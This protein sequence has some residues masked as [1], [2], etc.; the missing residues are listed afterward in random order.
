MIS[1]MKKRYTANKEEILEM[2]N[3]NKTQKMILK[4]QAGDIKS[5]L[6][7]MVDDG[8][9]PDV[10]SIAELETTNPD[11]R[12]AIKKKSKKYPG[13]FVYLFH[14]FKWGRFG[15][16][17]KF[18]YEKGTW[19][20]LKP[21]PKPPT[22]DDKFKSA[23]VESYKT[24]FG[25]KTKE[26]ALSSGW[27]LTNLEK[28][29]INGVELYKPK[30]RQG[31]VT[32]VSDEQ[33]GVLAAYKARYEAKEWDELTPAEKAL[34]WKEMDIPNSE[35]LFGRPVKLYTQTSQR[36]KVSD[37]PYQDFRKDYD[38]TEKDCVDFIQQYFD[39]YKTGRPVDNDYFLN[40]K[41]K[42]QFCKNK[43][44][45]RWGL[46][47]NANKL[48]KILDL[49]SRDIS[50]YQGVSL[51]PSIASEGSNKHLWLLEKR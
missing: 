12:F 47:V 44:H 24:K 14:D 5:K 18:V 31:V 27:D 1:K 50:E 9:V 20:P 8:Q 35:R 23:E 32:A 40:F 34:G 39:D 11:R 10:V 28:V 7:K 43:F 48:N 30:S 17:G 3:K 45:N 2:H 38:V 49:M 33:K 41:P 26:E 21:T 19:E 46:R 13:Q 4:E 51:P 16:D 42:V 6:R 15:T 25:A 22:V 36:M 37:Q 29:T